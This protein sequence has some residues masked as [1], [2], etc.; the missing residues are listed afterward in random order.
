MNCDLG[1][2]ESGENRREVLNE[3]SREHLTWHSTEVQVLT[4]TPPFLK[5]GKANQP[6]KSSFTFLKA[7]GYSEK[8][9]GS[10][11]ERTRA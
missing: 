3:V 4:A 6:S 11:K 9:M 10:R 7:I 8:Q 5:G 1:L 2:W